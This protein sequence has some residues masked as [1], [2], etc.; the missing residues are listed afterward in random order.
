LWLVLVVAR[1]AREVASLRT[2]DADA[3]EGRRPLLAPKVTLQSLTEHL[4]DRHATLA[5][6]LTGA[7]DESLVGLN[8]DPLHGIMIA[9]APG[10]QLW[11]GT[12]GSGAA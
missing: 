12:A 1:P 10:P 4:R 3:R 2:D 9:L 6:S 11:M 5:R 7:F 8:H